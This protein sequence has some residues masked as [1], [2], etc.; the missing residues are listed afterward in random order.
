MGLGEVD[1]QSRSKTCLLIPTKHE[2][3]HRLQDDHDTRR[4]IERMRIKR[5]GIG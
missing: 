3:N 4:T 2:H 5:R 1:E